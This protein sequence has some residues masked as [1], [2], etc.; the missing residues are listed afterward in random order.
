M[1]KARQ[2]E[3]FR[4]ASPANRIRS[5]VDDNRTSSLGQSDSSS[6]T[7]WPCANDN[8]IIHVSITTPISFFWIVA[9]RALL[10]STCVPGRRKSHQ[11]R[12]L[13]RIQLTHFFPMLANN[14]QNPTR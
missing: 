6:E 9:Q 10:E 3:L 11:S 1:H 13:S 7:I 14:A 12:V 8:G 2:R 5:F 4:A